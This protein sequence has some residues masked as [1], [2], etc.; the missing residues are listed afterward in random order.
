MHSGRVSL[1]GKALVLRKG[2]AV[3]HSHERLRKSWG[4]IAVD[5]RIRAPATL[6]S[7]ALP[8]RL[9]CQSKIKG[10]VELYRLATKICLLRVVNP[11]VSDSTAAGVVTSR[12]GIGAQSKMSHIRTS[13]PPA[14]V[15]NL[16]D[17][18]LRYILR[19]HRL[20][21]ASH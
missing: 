2:E 13:G 1:V 6:C 7:H 17:L 16:S 5:P 10:K 3:N 19:V 21:E 12:M 4:S 14:I 15:L 18:L 9:S 11:F 20:C 8:P